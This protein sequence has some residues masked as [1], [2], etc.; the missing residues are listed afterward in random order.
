M[1]RRQT[2]ILAT[3]LPPS[4]KGQRSP[5]T[6][7]YLLLLVDG[8]DLLQ[9]LEILLDQNQVLVDGDGQVEE[10]F[11]VSKL[12]TLLLVVLHV[13]FVLLQQLDTLTDQSLTRHFVPIC[14]RGRLLP[15]VSVA[16]C[17]LCDGYNYDST[18]IRR[19]FDCLSK[20]IKVTV[21]YPA[22]RRPAD[23]FLFIQAAVQQPISGRP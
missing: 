12:L 8:V 5:S 4:A 15:I 16:F 13:L 1:L 14:K 7:R 20:V 18:S 11:G 21:T 10:F 19:P 6:W 22:S 23:I 9:T 17:C 3:P 2:E